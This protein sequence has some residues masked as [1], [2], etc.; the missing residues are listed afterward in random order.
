[1]LQNAKTKIGEIRKQGKL[2]TKQEQAIKLQERHVRLTGSMQL[3][4]NKFDKYVKN[5]VTK[6]ETMTKLQTQ[7]QTNFQT[8]NAIF[9]RLLKRTDVCSERF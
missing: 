2:L 7:L 6:N 3:I 9:R 4:S 8:A 1:M 5:R